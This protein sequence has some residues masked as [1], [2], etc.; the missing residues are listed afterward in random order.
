VKLTNGTDNNAA[1]GP[2][3]APG[4]TVTFTYLVTNTTS[5]PLQTIVLIDDGGPDASFTPTPVLAAGTLF[6]VGDVNQNNILEQPE[7]WQYTATRIATPG[8][9]TN[10]G[11]VTGTSVTGN[12]PVSDTDVDN[13]AAPGIN[14][15][16]LTN[17]TDNNAA[18]GPIVAPG[19]IV[20][21]TYLVTNT[22][23][24]PLQTIVLVDDGGP[25]PS[26]TPTPVPGPNPAFNIG[27]VN[28]NNILEQTETWQYTATRIATP[29]QYTNTGTATGTSVTGNIPVSDTDVDNHAAP[30]INLVKLTNGTD[31][32]AAPGLVVTP[33]ST[34]TFTYLVTNT[35]FLPLQ[36]IVLVDD[37]GGPAPDFNPTPVLAPGTLFNVGDV[38]QN[39]ILEQP[40]TWQYTATRIATQLGQYTN[41]GTVTGTSVTGNIPV[42][43]TDVDNHTV[44]GLAIVKL[45]NGTDNDTAPGPFVPLNST[46]TFTYQVTNTGNVP[47]SNVTVTDDNGTSGPG[48]TADDRLLTTFTGDTDN[49]GLLDPGEIFLF[50]A[51]RLATPAGQYTNFATATGTPPGIP[52]ITTPPTPDNHFVA[53]PNLLIVKLTNGTDNNAAPGPIVPLNSTVTFTYQVTNTGNV[54]L[55]NVFVT[56][57]NGTRPDTTDD[58]VL[59]AFTGDTDGDGRLD[60]NETINNV[61]LDGDGRLDTGETFL[62]TATRIATPAGQYTNFATATGT[63]P[64]GVPPVTTPP[65]P[66]NHFVANPGFAIIKL[67]NGTD[68]DTAPGRSSRSIAR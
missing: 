14:L 25:D 58:R 64:P 32:N 36:T 2:I 43:D 62:F 63:P 68:N 9:Y 40:E 66:D 1:P 42:T 37:A 26:F 12:I 22:T 11:T 49:D 23:F 61:D 4:S 44:P 57:D 29:G 31:N 20:T 53:N 45:T 18:P 35:T 60:I 21:F 3:V 33:G 6:N 51:T 16:K 38:N 54:P 67:T 34:V 7:T 28:Q 48:N 19:S 56:D 24:L 55:S 50:T 5:L 8:Q 65:T 46:V 17:G 27:D 13:H 39:N 41:I 10:T 30:G 15:V 52:P 47:L 59:T